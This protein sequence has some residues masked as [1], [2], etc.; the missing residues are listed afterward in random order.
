MMLVASNEQT[1][2]KLSIKG[3]PFHYPKVNFY[4]SS[5]Y[6]IWVIGKSDLIIGGFLVSSPR[7]LL[8]VSFFLFR[9]SNYHWSSEHLTYWFFKHHQYWNS[10]TENKPWTMICWYIGSGEGYFNLWHF[11]K[12]YKEL[13]FDLK[14]VGILAIVLK[15]LCSINWN[16]DIFT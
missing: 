10:S 13:L 16:I 6:Y 8:I 12:E 5:T 11:C 15:K 3:T 4:Y 1:H 9:L 2:S 14:V 7:S